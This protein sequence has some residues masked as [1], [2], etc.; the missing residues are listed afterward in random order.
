MP[1]LELGA[2]GALQVRLHYVLPR[3]AQFLRDGV[4]AT[5]TEK[6]SLVPFNV[7]VIS[8]SRSPLTP[9][10]RRDFEITTQT[11]FTQLVRP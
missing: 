5:R 2:T 11:T 7:A 1:L 9:L 8:K 3:I 6:N 10:C 4:P